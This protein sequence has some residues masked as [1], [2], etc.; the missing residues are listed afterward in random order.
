MHRKKIMRKQ[1]KQI[2]NK[3]IEKKTNGQNFS[4][5]QKFTKKNS[6]GQFSRGHFS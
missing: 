1:N 2:Y 4:N 3:Q 5:G 6:W